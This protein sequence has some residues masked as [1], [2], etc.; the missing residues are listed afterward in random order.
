MDICDHAGFRL[1]LDQDG[2]QHQLQR[3]LRCAVQVDH[4]VKVAVPHGHELPQGQNC[5]HR[6]TDGQ[7]DLEEVKHLAGSIHIR[8]FA[9]LT[10]DALIIGAGNDHVPH[11]ECSRQNDRPHGIQQTQIVDEQVGGNQ[12]A[13]EKHR[14]HKQGV[15]DFFAFEVR[16]RHGISGKHRHS[17]RDD[18]EDD[19][20]KDC[21]LEADPDLLVR[22]DTLVSI[23]TPLAEIKGDALVLQRDRVHKGRDDDVD[24][25]NDDRQQEQAQKCVAAVQD[26][27]ILSGVEGHF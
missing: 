14:D 15:E 16:Q 13:A 9:Q 5:H 2:T 26:D 4:G 8:S 22:N 24:H 25:R 6:H 18:G 10:R 21:V 7:Q 27:L 19:R 1:A 11:A 20:V 23:Q 3:L 17:Y 12:T